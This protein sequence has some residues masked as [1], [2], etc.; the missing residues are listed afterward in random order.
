MHSFEPARL[1]GGAAEHRSGAQCT[2]RSPR[3]RFEGLR[4][5]A[6]EEALLE[7]PAVLPQLR[8][9]PLQ[10]DFPLPVVLVGYEPPGLEKGRRRYTASGQRRVQSWER[11][12][13]IITSDS[14]THELERE[15]NGEEVGDALHGLLVELAEVGRRLEVAGEHLQGAREGSL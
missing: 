1:Q 10:A 4:H 11:R 12:C 5:G 15:V 8:V 13:V 3:A 2:A 7:R 14:F 9:A 6:L